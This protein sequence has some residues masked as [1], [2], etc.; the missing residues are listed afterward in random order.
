MDIIREDPPTRTRAGSYEYSEV[1]SK[2]EA[3]PGNWYRVAEGRTNPGLAG[4]IKSGG[5]VAFRPEGAFEAVAR[6]D[7]GEGFTIW[8]RYVGG[9][10]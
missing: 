6:R 4:S 7:E 9:V 1:A 10:G 5:I 2:L 3:D 8:A